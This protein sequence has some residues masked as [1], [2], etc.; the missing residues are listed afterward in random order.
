M[1]FIFALG[2]KKDKAFPRLVTS[3][4][5]LYSPGR[6]A[7]RIGMLVL[8]RPPRNDQGSP[9]RS[10]GHRCFLDEVAAPGAS[11]ECAGRSP[12]TSQ[13][14]RQ[15]LGRWAPGLV[16][17]STRRDKDWPSL[18]RWMGSRA[19]WGCRKRVSELRGWEWGSGTPRLRVLLGW[20][21]GWGLGPRKQQT[22]VMLPSPP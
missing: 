17:K 13:P 16:E 4:S 14:P 21:W 1:V 20:G 15:L 2:F 7:D 6:K 5:P 10:T 12:C 3:L 9:V 22:K 18:F 8:S 19:S 11:G